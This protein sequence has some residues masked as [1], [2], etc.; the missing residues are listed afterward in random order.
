M[1]RA[2]RIKALIAELD[3]LV[4]ELIKEEDEAWEI[5]KEA[6]KKTDQVRGIRDRFYVELE[7]CSN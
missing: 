4:D 6:M 7:R 3:K 5:Y 2:E 1:T